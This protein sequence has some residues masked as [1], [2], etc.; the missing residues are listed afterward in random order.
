MHAA[1]IPMQTFMRAAKNSNLVW[2]LAIWMVT[3]C[4]ELIITGICHEFVAA[5]QL[6]LVGSDSKWTGSPPAQPRL[7]TF[8]YVALVKMVGVA[9]VRWCAPSRV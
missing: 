1:N 8:S 4:I 5:V 7:H 9:R 6:A 3:T 2:P